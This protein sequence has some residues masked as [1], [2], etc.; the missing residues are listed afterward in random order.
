MKHRGNPH[1][2]CPEGRLPG[3]DIAGRLR[4]GQVGEGRELGGRRAHEIVADANTKNCHQCYGCRQNEG[5][6]TLLHAA[7][8]S[9]YSKA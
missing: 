6:E 9:L 1:D 4:R 5:A 3:K 7:S 8:C 2:G